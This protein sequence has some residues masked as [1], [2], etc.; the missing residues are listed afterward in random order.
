MNAFQV[1]KSDHCGNQHN[2]ICQSASF[3]EIKKRKCGKII[4]DQQILSK[5]AESGKGYD[6]IEY[7]DCSDGCGCH[8]NGKKWLYKRKG[9]VF[10]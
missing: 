4:L 5:V 7:I 2:D 1:E 8:S 6:L 10:K 9:N 3:S